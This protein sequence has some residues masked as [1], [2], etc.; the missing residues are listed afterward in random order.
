[1]DQVRVTRLLASIGYEPKVHVDEFQAYQF[2]EKKNMFGLRHPPPQSASD[3][4]DKD[5]L[6][7]CCVCVFVFSIRMSMC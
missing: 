4:R 6:A 7:V 2:T 5:W 1:M 3:Q